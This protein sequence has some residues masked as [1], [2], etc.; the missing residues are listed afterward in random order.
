M[1]MSCFAL[2]VML[3]LLFPVTSKANSIIVAFGLGA[4]VDL[5]EIEV[6]LSKITRSA[7]TIDPDFLFTLSPL[8]VT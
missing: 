8:K 6:S 1:A 5:R 7:T 2:P 3:V 4:G